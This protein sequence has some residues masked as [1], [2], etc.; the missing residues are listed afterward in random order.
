[1][2]HS[3]N[4]GMMNITWRL[5]Q[6]GDFDE[7]WNSS[8]ILRASN[9]LPMFHTQQMHKDFIEKYSRTL[10]LSI[11]A[12]QHFYQDLMRD[13]TAAGKWFKGTGTNMVQ[14]Y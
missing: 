12:L 5:H 13:S 2:T 4:M 7:T 10:T 9:D 6:N 8:A 11:S 3:G 1:M 14:V